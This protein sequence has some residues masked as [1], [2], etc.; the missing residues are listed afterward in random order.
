MFKSIRTWILRKL[1]WGVLR[2]WLSDRKY[3]EIR[4]RIEQNQP[5]NLEK[6]ERF[7][8]KIQWVKLYD[9]TEL[10]K[11]VADRLKARYYVSKI[12]GDPHLI[13]LVDQFERLTPDIWQALPESFV[14]KANHGCE[15]VRIVR[16]KSEIRYEDVKKT[17]DSWIQ[18]EYFN[19]GREWV[20]KELP[21]T[22][23]A[24]KLLTDQNGKIPEDYKFFCF[25][26]RVE[27]IQIDIDRFVEQ[28]RNLYDR[29]FK[30]LEG[31]LLYPN[32][33]AS[34]SKPAKLKSA[35][36][37]AEALSED[38]NFLRVDLYLMENRI[39]FGELTNYPGNGFIEFEPES[40]E[41][42]AGSLLKLPSTHTTET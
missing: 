29:N 35:I 13:P 28:K 10:R 34:I 1:F 20:Y 26:G 2:H 6:P 15:M 41:Q 14:L 38:F 33:P 7:T 24:E 31:R 27:I 37:L 42:W 19:I 3:A 39:Y 17:T 32:S 25:H 40:L 22:I 4:Y 16:N 8:E 12:I 21:R 23:L 30:K 11:K 36:N 5:L 9:R 18:T